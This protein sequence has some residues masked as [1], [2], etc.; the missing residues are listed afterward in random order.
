MSF[1]IGF[2]G[3]GGFAHTHVLALK[4]L[5]CYYKNIPPIE[6][7]SVATANSASGKKF[8]D[9]YG[10]NQHPDVDSLLNDPVI[11]TVFILSPTG[12]HYEHLNKALDQQHIQNIY[13]EKPLGGTSA[14]ISQLLKKFNAKEVNLQLGFQFL[15]MPAI[16]SAQR[17]MSEIGKIIHFHVRYLHSGYLDRSYRDKRHNRLVATP[18]GGAVADLG[19]HLFSL[20]VAFL[21]NH[22]VVEHAQCAGTFPDVDKYSDL[23]TQIFVRD[24]NSDAI[25]TVIASR[26]SAGATDVLELEVRGTKG[27]I[28]ISSL[29]P[30]ILRVCQHPTSGVW[31]ERFCGNDYAPY[32]TFPSTNVPSGWMRPLVHALFVFF[33]KPQRVF[34]PTLLHGIEVQQLINTT[35][36]LLKKNKRYFGKVAALF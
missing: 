5:S 11:N 31:Q 27:A 15:Y 19:S 23:Y 36:S 25:G 28:Q 33:N 13:I 32:S 34:K 10:V 2:I 24:K 9:L 26:I 35:A 20:L 14:Q 12:L 1:K 18:E 22:L 7:C 3:A 8:A 29:Q 4:T 17:M 30:D 6:L 21:G 16:L